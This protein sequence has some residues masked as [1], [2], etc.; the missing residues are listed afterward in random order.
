M[1]QI[2]AVPGTLVFPALDH[3]YYQDPISTWAAYTKNEVTLVDNF[4]TNSIAAS[5]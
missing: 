5:N 1:T 4:E 2:D 3:R